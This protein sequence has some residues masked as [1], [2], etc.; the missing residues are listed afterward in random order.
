[1]GNIE[2]MTGETTVGVG[3]VGRRMSSGVFVEERGN[4]TSAGDGARLRVEEVE[5]RVVV[6]IFDSVRYV[7]SEVWQVPMVEAVAS[8][9]EMEFL[10]PVLLQARAVSIPKSTDGLQRV[11]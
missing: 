1:M 2:R 4:G 5:L 9:E 3:S 11:Q 8:A 10:S 7:L 6:V